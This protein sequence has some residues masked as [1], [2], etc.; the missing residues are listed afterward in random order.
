MGYA[1]R[2]GADAKHE[3]I[4]IRAIARQESDSCGIDIS[5]NLVAN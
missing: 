3:N 1:K 2:A 4:M 5:H